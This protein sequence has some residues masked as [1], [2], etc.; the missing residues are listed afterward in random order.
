MGALRS[1]SLVKLSEDFNNILEV[2]VDLVLQG[3][4]GIN[5]FDVSDFIHNGPF[6]VVEVFHDG[7]GSA[8]AGVS[9]PKRPGDSAVA[10]ES[11]FSWAESFS[12]FVDFVTVEERF[13]SSPSVDGEV[14]AIDDVSGARD[15]D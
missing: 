6:V 5:G 2:F 13:D 7:L 15:A 11:V 9:T 10:G 1:D 3:R 12:H 8:V 14:F 4:Y